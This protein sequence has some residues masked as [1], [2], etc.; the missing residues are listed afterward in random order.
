MSVF[1]VLAMSAGL[2][3]GQSDRPTTPNYHPVTVGDTWTYRL[4]DGNVTQKV[5]AVERKGDETIISVGRDLRGK[6]VPAYKVSVTPKGVFQVEIGG[7]P[8]ET[9]ACWL[10]L[11]LKPGDEWEGSTPSSRFARAEKAKV[12]AGRAE[13]IETPAGKF[14]AARSDRGDLGWETLPQDELDGS[15]AGSG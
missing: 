2:L 5:I 14:Q 11:P 13:G 3:V 15:G 7:R 1:S 10:K 12:S 6:V 9:A 8:I 4:P